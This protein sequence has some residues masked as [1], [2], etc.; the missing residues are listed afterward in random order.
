MRAG[1]E[2]AVC[3]LEWRGTSCGARRFYQ[4]LRAVSGRARFRTGAAT[5]WC[6]RAH[7]STAPAV[8]VAECAHGASAREERHG[9]AAERA[10]ARPRRTSH[11]AN[12]RRT[13]VA[14]VER[15]EKPERRPRA[16]EIMLKSAQDSPQR[17]HRSS[18]HVTRETIFTYFTFR[19]RREAD[20]RHSTQ[21][22]GAVR[23]A[24]E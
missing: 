24:H 4:D 16:A 8:A 15:N 5:A 20:T 22:Q 12:V 14:L 23:A 3:A 11:R 13:C 19:Y 10:R 2:R 7:S 1:F 6:T 9:Q 18:D 17:D 21:R